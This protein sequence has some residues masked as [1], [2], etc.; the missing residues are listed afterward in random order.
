MFG[1]I[2][3]AKSLDFFQCDNSVYTRGRECINCIIQTKLASVSLYCIKATALK[4]QISK[5]YPHVISREAGNHIYTSNWPATSDG[6]AAT[7][8]S[9]LDV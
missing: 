2:I 9:G 8:T 5:F 1:L 4:Q 3:R 6:Y 7:L